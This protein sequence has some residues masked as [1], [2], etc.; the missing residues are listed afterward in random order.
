MVKENNVEE[1]MKVNFLDKI[2]VES[3]R[4]GGDRVKGV[5][6]YSCQLQASL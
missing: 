2:Y 4:R 5:D 1:A 3:S 6:R